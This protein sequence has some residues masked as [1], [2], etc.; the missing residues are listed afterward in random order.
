MS[1]GSTENREVTGSTPVGATVPFPGFYWERDFFLPV[2]GTRDDAELWRLL[3]ICPG[4]LIAPCRYSPTQISRVRS[5]GQP[6]GRPTPQTTLGPMTASLGDIAADLAPTGVLRAAINLG[7]PVLVQGSA[8]VPTG[9][10]VDI[11]LEVGKRLGLPVEYVCV[12]SAGESFEATVTGVADMCFL[13]IEPAR[14]AELAFTAAYA[15]VEGVFVVP[16]NS[17][18]ITAADVDRRG[19]R[20]AVNRGAAY[21]LFLTRTLRHASLV[22]A[23]S[24]ID[25]F[26][27]HGLEAAAG[28]RQPM[29][30]AVSAD[31]RLRLIGEPFMQIQQAVATTRSRLPETVDF[32]HNAVEAL[33]SSGFIA[34]ALIRANQPDAMIAPPG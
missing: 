2:F 13:A 29:V 26:R 4:P 20:I 27:V 17:P 23:A 19:V 22:R 3:T 8:A 9:V 33:K 7:N 28:I 11:S 6:D 30:E 32:L 25:E 1:S 18:L 24:G 14:A 31:P 15:V 10:T 34:E 21:D 12:G 5:V 16:I